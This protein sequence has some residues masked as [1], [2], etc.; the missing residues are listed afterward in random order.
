MSKDYKS[1]YDRLASLVQGQQETS[2]QKEMFKKYRKYFRKYEKSKEI[3]GKS[4][5]AARIEQIKTMEE[6]LDIIIYSV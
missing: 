5:D 3:N 2:F 6:L 1:E 4:K